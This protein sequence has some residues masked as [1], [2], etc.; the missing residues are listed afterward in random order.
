MR[1]A[2]VDAAVSRFLGRPTNIPRG[3]LMSTEMNNTIGEA[4]R[5]T[6]AGRLSQATEVLQRGLASMGIAAPSDPAARRPLGELGRLALPASDRRPLRRPDGRDS[7]ATPGRAAGRA[8]GRAATV[9]PGAAG[10]EF[11]QLTHA[12]S[13]GTRR[14]H[15]YTPSSY[16]GRPVPLVVMLHGGKQ[17]APDFAAGTRMNELAERHSFLVAYPEQ[18]RE[19]NQGRYWNWFSAADQRAEAGEPAVIAGITR[20]VMRDLV[21][22]PARVYIAGLSAG[23][24]MAAVMAATHPRL[25]AAVG[26]HSGIAYRA[27]HDV[28]S[29]FA[30]MRTG[31]TPAASSAVPMIVIHGDRDT[32]VAPVN[33]DKLIASRLAIGDVTGRDG[34]ITIQGNSGHSHAR[35]VHHNRAGLPVAEALIVHGG[36]HAWYGGSPAGSYTDSRSPD[37]SAEMIRFFLQHQSSAHTP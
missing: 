13:A 1:W 25:Y 30:A 36:R 24:A 16:T 17:D 28:G 23:G 19:A 12:E 21:V 11:R 5:L 7:H 2:P 26:I 6:R 20:M 34:P 37:S 18:S 14:Y 4:L 10:A 27:A 33:A 3:R 32:I 8:S 22:D 9:R 35:T 15:L 31:G 29:A